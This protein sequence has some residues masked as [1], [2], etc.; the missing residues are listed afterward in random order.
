MP[1]LQKGPGS[2][3]SPCTFK[4]L[5]NPKKRTARCFIFT[6]ECAQ[7]RPVLNRS[8]TRSQMSSQGESELQQH[9]RQ[10]LRQKETS[11]WYISSHLGRA[12]HHFRLLQGRG[13]PASA[14][15]YCD[16][17]CGFSLSGGSWL[18]FL[19]TCRF[20][21]PKKSTHPQIQWVCGCSM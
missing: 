3:G 12:G 14:A 6:A 11:P 10:T 8:L 4:T 17:F 7:M 15:A 19:W 13:K 16:M 9:Q 5:G 20:K 1:I 2:S 18:L 21:F